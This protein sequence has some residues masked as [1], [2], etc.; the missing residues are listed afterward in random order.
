MLHKSYYKGFLIRGLKVNKGFNTWS[1]NIIIYKNKGFKEESYFRFLYDSYTNSL[2]ESL[3]DVK[4]EIDY[5]INMGFKFA[6]SGL[7]KANYLKS[8]NEI[9]GG[10]IC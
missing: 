3:K 7:N 1:F 9:K 4:K 2:K 5:N 6:S 10:L 8:I